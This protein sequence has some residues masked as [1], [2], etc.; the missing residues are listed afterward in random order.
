MVSLNT[1]PVLLEFY[2]MRHAESTANRSRMASGSGSDSRLTETGVG[3]AELAADFLAQAEPRISAIY[4]TRMYRAFESAAPVQRRTGIQ[5]HER[6]AFD[7][8]MLGEWE[9]ISWDRVGALFASGEDP[10]G[11]ESYQEFHSRVFEG[12]RELSE[13]QSVDGEIPL[14]VSHGGVWMAIHKVC[15][16]QAEDWPENCDIYH[17]KLTGSWDSPRLEAEP[18]FH[19][20]PAPDP[21]PENVMNN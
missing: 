8:Q 4:H 2:F 13:A 1:P 18:V 21:D 9:G 19:L 17:A 5:I 20:P 14:I 6:G 15:G 12:L 10:P 7:E 16:L 3:Q 11:G